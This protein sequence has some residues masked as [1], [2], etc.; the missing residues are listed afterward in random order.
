MDDEDDCTDVE[1]N[2]LSGVG[3]QRRKLKMT[4]VVLWREER[5]SVEGRP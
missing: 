1:C 4:I 3:V 2:I 5:L